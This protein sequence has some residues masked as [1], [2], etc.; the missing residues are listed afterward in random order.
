VRFERELSLLQ[1]RFATAF[2]FPERHHRCGL[3]EEESTLRSSLSGCFPEGR[4]AP[5][6]TSS[7]TGRGCDC[8]V[9]RSPLERGEFSRTGSLGLIWH[10]LSRSSGSTAGLSL[11]WY[12]MSPS[13]RT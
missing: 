8:G 2:G 3:L 1:T 9:T 7:R 4:A 5:S 12:S 13:A 10:S 11:L 6:G